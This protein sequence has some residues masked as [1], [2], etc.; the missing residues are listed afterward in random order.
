MN[1]DINKIIKELENEGASKDEAT[2]LAYFS[3][4]LSNGLNFERSGETKRKFLEKVVR[5]TPPAKRNYFFLHRQLLASILGIMM[6]LGFAT[7]VSAQDS[8]PGQPLYQVKRITENIVSSVNPSFNSEIL[9]RRS[10]EIKALSK[11]TENSSLE[12]SQNVK[13]TIRDYEHVL[14]SDKAINKNAI[15]DSRTNLEEASQNSVDGD[16][17]EI[18]DVLRKTQTKQDDVRGVSITPVPTVKLKSGEQDSSRVQ[19]NSENSADR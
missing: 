13:N 11:P 8:I 9:K 1:N 3:K 12:N 19:N 16:K 17:Q 18:E 15:E 14:N 2:Q 7:L 5:I 6:L 4:N 10:V